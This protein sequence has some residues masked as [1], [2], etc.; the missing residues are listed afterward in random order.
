MEEEKKKEKGSSRSIYHRLKA[1]NLAGLFAS[2]FLI[3]PLVKCKGVTICCFV[4]LDPPA[5]AILPLIGAL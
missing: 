4:M 5:E 2:Q 1:I 3:I